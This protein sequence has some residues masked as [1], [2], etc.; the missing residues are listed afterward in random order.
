MTLLLEC[1]FG[2]Q[3]YGTDTP[4]SDVDIGRV[5]LEP[6][7]HIFGI[8]KADKLKQKIDDELDIREMFL[9]RFIKL[10]A[11]GNPNTLEWLYTPDEHILHIDPLFRT[12]IWDNRDVLLNRKKLIAS[13][14]GF[15]KSQ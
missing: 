14:L 5:L 7:T 10:C 1:K 12:F 11:D 9:R 6:K 13:H 4:E 3:V 15:A 8:Q 2:S